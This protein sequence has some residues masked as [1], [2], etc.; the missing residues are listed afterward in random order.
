M[1]TILKLMPEYKCYPIWISEN[2]GVFDNIAPNQLNISSNLK[3]KIEEWDNVFEKTFNC[4]NPVESGF[5]KSD[6]TCFEE[7]GVEIWKQL[8][9]ELSEFQII[10]KS[11]INF[12]EYTKPLDLESDIL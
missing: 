1:K 11:Q 3:S 4:E 5:K 2:G 12:K 8:I 10:Y 6:L 7:I 9:L